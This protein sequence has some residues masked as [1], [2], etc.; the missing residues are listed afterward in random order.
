MQPLSSQAR[1]AFNLRN[2]FRIEA[3]ELMQDRITADRL[4]REEANLGWESL[5]N[6]IDEKL[7]NRG[8]FNP[9][10]DQVYEE[11][12]NSSQRSRQSVNKALG[13]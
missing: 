10:H 3:R 4:V 1:Q 9:T 11:I 8:V 2:Q 7:I 6:K 13:L 12:I 5:L